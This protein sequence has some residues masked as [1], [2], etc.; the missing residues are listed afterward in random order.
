L[1]LRSGWKE[2]HLPSHGEL[3][4]FALIAGLACFLATGIGSLPASLTAHASDKLL[5][6]LLGFAGGIMIA[7]TAFGL[8]VPALDTGGVGKTA[9]GLVAGAGVLAIAD[10]TVPHL[11]LLEGPEGPRISLQRAWLIVLAITIH[12]FPEGLAIGVT[13][14]RGDLNAAVILAIGIAIQD[15]PEG[16]AVALPL[17]REGYSSKRA[18]A[19]AT[20]TGIAEPLAALAGVTLILVFDP[21]LPLG[22]A[23][24]AGAMTYVVF[25]E[26]LP[27]SFRRGYRQVATTGALAG[28]ILMATMELA[29]T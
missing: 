9:I 14:G 27:E 22:L 21:L 8:L 12:N 4:A 25:D 2:L 18:I 28:F 3:I 16:L 11:H 29:F 17:V 13:F 20:L 6:G 1:L 24:A 23:F 26:I 5:D 10:R 19:Y 7:V 15:M